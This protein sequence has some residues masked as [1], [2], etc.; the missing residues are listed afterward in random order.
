MRSM[1]SGGWQAFHSTTA[2]RMR[3]VSEAHKERRVADSLRLT[4]RSMRRRMRR[5][6]RSTKNVRGV[7]ALQLQSIDPGGAEGGKLSAVQP[8]REPWEEHEVGAQGEYR[9]MRS[10]RS[11]GWQA[12]HST[13]AE[14]MSGEYQRRARS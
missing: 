7:E 3:G 1:R 6:M 12:F 4:E 8:Q 9:P 14:R 2:E 10:T 13:T 5:S 11:G